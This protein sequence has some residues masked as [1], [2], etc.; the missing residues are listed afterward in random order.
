MLHSHEWINIQAGRGYRSTVRKLSQKYCSAH[1]KFAFNY[2]LIYVPET[3]V[4]VYY[5][6]LF[7]SAGVKWN[8]L[9]F[10]VKL[11]LTY[12]RSSCGTPL[13]ICLGVLI[14]PYKRTHWTMNF[15]HEF[16]TVEKR[17]KNI[18]TNRIKCFTEY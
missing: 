4:L 18:L 15:K 5:H 11:S 6:S 10:T 8:T 14:L 13:L 17:R 9:S 16:N 2:I 12:E 7:L 1:H 3:Y